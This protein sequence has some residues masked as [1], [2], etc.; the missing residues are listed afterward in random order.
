MAFKTITIKGDPVIGERKAA[1]AITPGFLLE[2]NTSDKVQKHATAGGSAYAMFALEDENQG[3]EISDAYTTDNECL[4]GMFRPGDEVN[5]L[6]ANGEDA[7]VGNKLESNG[8][9]Y[10][11]VVDS[12]VSVGDIGIQSIVCMVL[13]ALDMSG[14]SGVDP[15]S[16]R[17]RCMVI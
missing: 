14:S 5:A 13:V 16:Q 9:G 6:L 7:S 3:K 2:L 10:L 8:D 11:R 15:A 1:A 12:D 17:I 4:F